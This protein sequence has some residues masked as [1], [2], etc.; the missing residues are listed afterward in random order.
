MTCAEAYDLILEAD[1]GE[2]DGTRE[3]PLASHLSE[4]SRCRQLARVVLDEEASLGRTLMEVVPAPDL[5]EVLD[6]GSHRP[7]RRRD[8]WAAAISLAAAAA[9]VGVFLTREP[10]LPGPLY[11]APPTPVGLDVQA[12]EG[13]N[14]AVLKTN[15]PDITVLWLF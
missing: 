10:Q 13:R 9:L 5:D 11:T 2:L 6:Q 8:S 15:D 3:G 4:C 7:P 1:P 12:P 14:V